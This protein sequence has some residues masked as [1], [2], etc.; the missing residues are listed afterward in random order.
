MS[1]GRTISHL[2]ENILEK[3]PNLF[4][5]NYLD[6]LSQK[7]TVD[8]FAQI[9]EELAVNYSCGYFLCPNGLSS[10]ILNVT[11]KYKICRN[12]IF[13]ISQR[14]WFCSDRCYKI[15]RSLLDQFDE[16][17]NPKLR[18]VFPRLNNENVMKNEIKTG[19]KLHLTP[20]DEIVT[21]LKGLTLDSPDYV[22]R[23]QNRVLIEE[24]AS[25]DAESQSKSDSDEFEM[26]D[27]EDDTKYEYNNRK[28][29]NFLKPASMQKR[30]DEI[31]EKYFDKVHGH[32]IPKK[33]TI[34]IIDPKPETS[35]RS[36]KSSSPITENV[37]LSRLKQFLNEWLENCTNNA[38]LFTGWTTSEPTT[39][40]Q[41]RS[42]EKM[43]EDFRKK[44]DQFF[45]GD[46]IKLS[47]NDII[48]GSKS[49]STV[50]LPLIDSED[51]MKQRRRIVLNQLKKRLPD[52]CDVVGIEQDRAWT[53]LK[54]IVLK[55]KLT[56]TNVVLNLNEWAI[57][58]VVFLFI[59]KN[60]ND[61][62]L[63]EKIREISCRIGFDLS[64]VLHVLERTKK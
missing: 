33:K 3:K 23:H 2:I 38:F 30:L 21:I 22:D 37:D 55:L 29:K 45:K 31:R 26:S 42:R 10:D 41:G 54:K 19:D 57:V 28:A 14:K 11:Q 51:Q 48:D 64:F 61:E 13:D 60:H 18:L 49:C 7:L 16:L 24:I 6:E 62:R 17:P 32:L 15:F 35:L 34:S 59:S 58:C 39:D 9:A 1:D 50:V 40:D 27:Q 53:I 47:E 5:D 44:V 63:N 43:E 52:A 8:S 25:Y 36:P 56:A 4:D 46:F 12:Q 20:A